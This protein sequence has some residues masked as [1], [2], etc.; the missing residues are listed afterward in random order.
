MTRQSSPVKSDSPKVILITGCSSGF[1][2]LTAARLAACGHQVTAT[3]RNLTKA[4]D[5]NEEVQKRGGKIRVLELDVTKAETV[6][7]TIEIIKKDYGRL[8]VLVNN[9]GFG[10]GGFFEDLTQVQI[11]EQLETNFFGVQNVTREV[12]PF[13]REQKSGLII[14]MSSIAG[15]YALPGF[16]AYTASKW[17]LEGFS[18]SLY[19]ELKP[20]GIRVCLIEPGTYNTTIFHQNKRYAEN[21]SNPQSPYCELSQLLDKKV[22]D[23]VSKVKRDPADIARLLEKIINSRNPSFRNF[24]DLQGRAIYF[25]RR[26]LPF[27]LF[28]GILYR[29]LFWK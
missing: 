20:F 18:E 25:L 16:G 13:M 4:K 1:G 8:D 23:Y 17:A 2:L 12:L 15:L 10:I 14:N 9:A 19:Y 3:V 6:R 26:L 22:Q 7:K 11:R 21:F 24:P 29:L 5:L 28:S 27:R